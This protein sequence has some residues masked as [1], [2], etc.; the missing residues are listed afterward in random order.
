MEKVTCAGCGAEFV[1][2]PLRGGDWCLRCGASLGSP[3]A[4]MP[5]E[6]EPVALAA[7]GPVS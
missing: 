6:P 4:D 3:E 5:D 1:P 7:E 2:E